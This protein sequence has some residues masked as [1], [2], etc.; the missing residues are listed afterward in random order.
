MRARIEDGVVYSPYPDVEMLNCSF[1][2]AVKKA[3]LANP[4]KVVLID[5]A[6][7][8]TLGDFHARLRR[9][10]AGFQQHGLRPGDRVCVHIGNSVENFVAMWGCVVA[11]ASIVLAKPSL[12]ARELRYQMCDSDSTHLLVEPTLV[13]KAAKASADLPLKGRFTVGSFAAEGFVS[14]G[15]LSNIDEDTFE[16]VSVKDPRDC[17]L[18]ILYTSGTTGLPKGVEL[19]HHGFLAN[20]GMWRWTSPWD[21]SDVVLLPTPITHGSGLLSITISVLVGTTCVIVPPSQ[22]LS[23]IAKVIDKHKVTA[24]ILLHWH[25]QTLVDEMRRT[26][27]RLPGLRR[28]CTGGYPLSQRLYDEIRAAF[29][30]DLQCLANVYAMTEAMALISSPSWEHATGVDM[31]FPAPAT[32]FKIVDTATGTRLG[33]NQTGEIRFR[34]PTVMKGYYK[35]PKETADFFDEE[36]WCKS[37]DA[38]YYDEDGRIHFVQRFKE[39]IKCMDNQVV[40]TEL[41]H[42]L[43]LE[44]SQDVV[45]ICVVGIPDRKYGEAPAAAVVLRNKLSQQELA[46]LSR[47][48]KATVAENF[49]AHK[50]LYGGVFFVDSIPKTES[51]KTNRTAVLQKCAP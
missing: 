51:G 34:A 11:G 26:G 24:A 46:D 41:E 31:G 49:A 40:P 20:I 16:E 42:M 23:D 10:A 12:T 4:G 19:T 7:A 33:P 32:Q 29:G 8:L 47:R 27:Q 36:G 15:Q 25:L 50:Q 5:D 17:I 45:D 28:V 44:H 13:E 1:Y 6:T 38:G 22:S 39:M 35:R 30:K 43:L 21:D 3:A 37:G 9:Y 18:A 14:M 48:I 2:E